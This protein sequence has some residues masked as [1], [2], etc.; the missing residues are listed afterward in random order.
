MIQRVVR[1]PKN[2]KG[3][4]RWQHCTMKLTCNPGLESPLLVS[5]KRKQAD[6]ER[7]PDLSLAIIK[8]LGPGEYMT[9]EPGQPPYGHFALAVTDY[10]HGTAP[11]RRYVDLINQRLVK[12][13]IN[14]SENPIP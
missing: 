1:I 11:N 6:P 14:R 9:L 10:T 2:G 3:S 4:C 12:S 8:L 7:F 5:D 13:V